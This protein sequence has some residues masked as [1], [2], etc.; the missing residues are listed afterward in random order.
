MEKSQSTS[1][2]HLNLLTVTDFEDLIVKI[3]YKVASK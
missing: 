3:V 2:Q 1:E